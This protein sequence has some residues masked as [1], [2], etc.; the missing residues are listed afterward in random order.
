MQGVHISLSVTVCL[1]VTSYGYGFDLIDTVAE[2]IDPIQNAVDVAR[3]S[4]LSRQISH[5][6]TGKI[7]ACIGSSSMLST[8]HN[9][10]STDHLPIKQQTNEKRLHFCQ[11]I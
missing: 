1:C 7:T 10:D 5:L 8:P 2:S 6:S 3:G 9:R 11:C 4:Q